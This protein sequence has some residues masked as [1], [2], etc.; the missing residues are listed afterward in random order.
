MRAIGDFCSFF[1]AALLV[2][3][4]WAHDAIGTLIAGCA[5][6]LRLIAYV[7]TERRCS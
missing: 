3:F 4:A 7:R 1:N 5:V 2:Y 6:G